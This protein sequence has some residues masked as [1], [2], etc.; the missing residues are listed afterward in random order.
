[1]ARFTRPTTPFRR[2]PRRQFDWIGGTSG[3]FAFTAVPA[4]TTVLLSSFDTR[5][6][7]SIPVAPFTI[8]RVRGRLL[9]KTDS[10]VAAEQPGGA[11][12]ICVVNGE[13]FDAGVASIIAPWT[14]SFDD[15]WF[16]HQ[17]WFS[18]SFLDAAGG[19]FPYFFDVS[20]DGKAMRKV[21]FGD[22]IVF[23]VENAHATHGAQIMS[24]SRVGVKLH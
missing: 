11:F 22:V 12:G 3:A 19:F 15:R 1:M 4:A 10:S 13:A 16:Y 14:E 8:T 7:G 24:N 18:P 6:A 2:G 23:M 21:D 17:Y 5:A 9:M 20:I